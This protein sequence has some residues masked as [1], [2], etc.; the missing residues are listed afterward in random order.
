MAT[1]AK[2]R[3]KK[4]QQPLNISKESGPFLKKKKQRN[5]TRMP[6]YQNCLNGS[7]WLNKVATRAKNRKKKPLNN[8]SSKANGPISK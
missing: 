2:N 7:F 3:K 5:V 6:L 1:R 4:Q 8:I